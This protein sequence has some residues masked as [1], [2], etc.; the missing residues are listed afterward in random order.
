MAKQPEVFQYDADGNL[1]N[2]GRWSYIWDAENRLTEM[3]NTSHVGPGFDLDFIND[4][5]GRRI[6]KLVATNGI[7]ISTN[8]F[9]YDGWNVVAETQPNYA[10]IRTY[11]WGNDLSG[12]VQGVGGVGGLLEVS[13]FGSTVT[14]C[15]PAYD[16][17]GN[18]MTLANA[19]NGTSVANYDYGPFG[20]VVRSTGPMAKANPMR[21][22][23]KYADDESDLLY[24]GYRFYK[25]STGT[26]LNRDPLGDLFFLQL[27][28]KNKS[29]LDTPTIAPE[30][31][32]KK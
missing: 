27:L 24:Y 21:F 6:Q 9:I 12:T 23:T 1:T 2:D 19:A 17:N 7:S 10:L 18:I 26:W 30:L 11:E 25:P 3:T 20:E 28:I 29:E 31:P 22:S 14:N 4:Y 13:Y 15:F 5:K 16:G 8:K 32:M